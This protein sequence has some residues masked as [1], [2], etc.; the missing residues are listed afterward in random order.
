MN[1]EPKMQHRQPTIYD[2]QHKNINI[3]IQKQENKSSMAEKEI[4]PIKDETIP[5]DPH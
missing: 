5:E 4:K 1:W 2:H 3:A